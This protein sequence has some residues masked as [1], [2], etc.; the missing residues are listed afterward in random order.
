MRPASRT[1]TAL[2]PGTASRRRR[3]SSV[4]ADTPRTSPLHEKHVALGAKMADPTR[5]VFCFIGD[6]TF[7]L[8]SQEIMTAVQEGLKITVLLVDNYGY[9]SIAALSET[10]G[11]Q[12]FACRFTHR[13]EDGQFSDD[14]VD[15]DLGVWGEPTQKEHI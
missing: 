13:G 11:S 5:D 3:T 4:C 14:R 8:S 6:G 12:A 2:T 9:G 1:E 7:L 15:I 10:R